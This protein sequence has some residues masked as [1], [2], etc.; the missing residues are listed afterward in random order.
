MDLTD[1][2]SPYNAGPQQHY[3]AQAALDHLDRWAAGGDAPPS[4]PR[5]DLDETRTRYTA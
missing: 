2:H 1:S 4:A 3:V 5:I